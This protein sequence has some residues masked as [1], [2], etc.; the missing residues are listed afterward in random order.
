[1]DPV[2]LAATTGVDV[3][4]LAPHAAAIGG[5]VW[6]LRKSKL[7]DYV[8]ASWNYLV[9]VAIGICDALVSNLAMGKGLAEAAQLAAVGTLAAIGG[10]KVMRDSPLPYG[11]PKARSS[12]SQPPSGVA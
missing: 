6:L 8:P 12:D 10:H 5:V 4:A 9:P 2:T 7:W 3:V 1:M 11:G